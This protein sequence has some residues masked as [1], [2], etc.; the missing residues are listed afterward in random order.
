M[1]FIGGTFDGKTTGTGSFFEAGPS[2][3]CTFI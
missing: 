1:K 3:F 2:F